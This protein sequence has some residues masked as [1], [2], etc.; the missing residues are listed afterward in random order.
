MSEEIKKVSATLVPELKT[1]NPRPFSHQD[2]YL[3]GENAP[4]SNHPLA[5]A[6]RAL[7]DAEERFR[8]A[9][10]EFQRELQTGVRLEK[11][12]PQWVCGAAGK[13]EG[14]M[15]MRDGSLHCAVCGRSC[16]PSDQT[17]KFRQFPAK[18]VFV[19]ESAPARIR[20]KCA[21]MERAQA[22]R[23]EKRRLL[24]EGGNDLNNELAAESARARH[25]Q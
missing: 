23:D 20:R 2:I 15:E 4:P 24:A 19:D 11:V 5:E 18:A 12:E 10:F 1:A 9:C 6:R 16:G 7:S 22:V 14:R 13:C 8:E 21:A 17:L 25:R 3:G